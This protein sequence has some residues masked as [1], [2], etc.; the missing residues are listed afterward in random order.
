MAK[1]VNKY[2]GRITWRKKDMKICKRQAVYVQ[3]NTEA[4][5]RNICCRE[6]LVKYYIFESVSVFVL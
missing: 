5:E 3:R 1:F 6:K 4:L 2:T